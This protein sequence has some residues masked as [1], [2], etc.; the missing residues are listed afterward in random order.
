MEARRLDGMT[1]SGGVPPATQASTKS[2]RGGNLRFNFAGA[3][4]AST[5]DG[6]VWSPKGYPLGAQADTHRRQLQ[7][8]E[9]LDQRRTVKHQGNM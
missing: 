4:R 3:G 8:Q 7:G 9:N 5:E 1:G 6:G 2:Q